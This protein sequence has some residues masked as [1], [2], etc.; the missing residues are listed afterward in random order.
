VRSLARAALSRAVG[1]RNRVAL[2]V[3]REEVRGQG[4]HVDPEDPAAH[5]PPSVRWTEAQRRAK[6]S[7]TMNAFADA[8]RPPGRGSVR[9]GVIGDLAAYHGLTADQVVQRCLHWERDSVREWQRAER[10]SAA[11]LAQFYDTVQ[12]WSFDLLW[13][14]YLQSAGYGYPASV[15]VADRIGGSAGGARLLDLG[16]GVGVTAQLFASL[17]YDVTLADVSAPLL[18]FAR[19]RLER[20][21]VRASYVHLPAELGEATYDVITAIDVMAHVPGAADTA[22]RL[23]RALRTGGVFVANFDVRRRS[24][25]NASH[26][27]EDDLPL[28]WVVQ[29]AGFSPVALIDGVIWV[30]RAQATAG[31]AWRL[32]TALTWVRLA[33]PLA[34]TI[35]AGRRALARSALVT[36]S[37]VMRRR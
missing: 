32:R 15:I 16:S 12:S 9:D 19:W 2:V 31:P 26:L 17:G 37:R 35:R 5:P 8:L 7:A 20:R 24:P 21:G 27:Y 4:R 14:A 23:H 13:Y 18:A 30:Y 34:R 29:R 6:T 33:S 36:A 3:L 28:R 11:G 10:A 1:L 25:A 22:R